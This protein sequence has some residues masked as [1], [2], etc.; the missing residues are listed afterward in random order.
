VK[1]A[2]TIV[3]L[4]LVTHVA[5]ASSVDEFTADMQKRDGFVPVYY[6]QSKDKVFL[7]ID[8]LD[9]PFI[10]QSSLP[11]GVGSNDIGLDRGQLGDTRLTIFQRYGN[12]I[13]L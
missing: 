5:L 13:L 4:W 11:Q 6:D 12:K 7:A 3:L 8:K 10:F 2:L 1:T 9:Q